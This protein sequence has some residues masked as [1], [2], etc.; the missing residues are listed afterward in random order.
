MNSISLTFYD[1]AGCSG[2]SLN[3]WNYYISQNADWTLGWSTFTA[4]A[5]TA[6]ALVGVISSYQYIDDLYVNTTNQF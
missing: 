3:D 4:P 6:S 1:G 5:L 2:N